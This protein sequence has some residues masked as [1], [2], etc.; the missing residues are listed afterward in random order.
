MS[1]IPEWVTAIAATVAAGGVIFAFQQFRL[2]K[3]IAQVQFE[4]GLAKEYRDLAGAIPTKAMLGEDLS[5]TEY[6]ESF[7]KLFRYIDLTNE[8]VSLRQRGRI[9]EEVWWFWLAGIKANLRLPAFHRAWTEI[10]SRSESF[11]ELRRL[12]NEDFKIDPAK[13]KN[14]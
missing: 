12:E 14:T 9:S 11:Q 6:Q 8:Q 4:D 5:E 3:K 2:S 1:C 13:W 10:K 7:G